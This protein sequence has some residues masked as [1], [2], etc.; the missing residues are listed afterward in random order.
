MTFGSGLAARSSCIVRVPS[1]RRRNIGFGSPNPCSYGKQPVSNPAWRC[2]LMVF[3]K[4]LTMCWQMMT[5]RSPWR[6]I[7]LC[8][9]VAPRTTTGRPT[10]MRSELGG[11]PNASS[12]QAIPASFDDAWGVAQT[13]SRPQGADGGPRACPGRGRRPP[14]HHAL[15]SA[16]HQGLQGFAALY[17]ARLLPV[18]VNDV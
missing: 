18:S 5:A 10:S 17:L 8:A 4:R 2:R 13:L 11:S 3:T 1:I 7:A 15:R 6:G 12:S 14:R 9:T 16:F